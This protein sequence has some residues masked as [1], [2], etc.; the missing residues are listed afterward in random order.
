[1]VKGIPGKQSMQNIYVYLVLWANTKQ[2]RDVG[3]FLSLSCHSNFMLYPHEKTNS[4]KP[5]I[6]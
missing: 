5:K 6:F 1:M 3:E 2:K 4:T